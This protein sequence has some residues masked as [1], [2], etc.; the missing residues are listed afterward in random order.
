MTT[1]T[2]RLLFHKQQVH[3]RWELK[4]FKQQG[5]LQKRLENMEL[6]AKQNEVADLRVEL[7]RRARDAGNETKMTKFSSSCGSNFPSISSV[8]LSDHTLTKVSQWMDKT[9]AKNVAQ[10]INVS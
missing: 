3:E 4:G 9:E 10:S 8:G 1:A 7:A 2:K 6:E 5:Q